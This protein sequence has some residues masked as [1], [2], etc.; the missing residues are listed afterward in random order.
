MD[1]LRDKGW[2]GLGNYKFLSGLLFFVMVALY[3]FFR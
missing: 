3:I 1:V 2:S